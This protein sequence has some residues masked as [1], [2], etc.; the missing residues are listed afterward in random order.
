MD[1]AGVAAWVGRYEQAWRTEGTATLA[2]LFTADASYRTSPWAE[3][4][5]GLGAIQGMWEAERQGPHEDFAMVSEV[6]AV[7]GDTAVVRVEVVYRYQGGIRWRDLW[8]VRFASDGRCAA[9]EEWP[10]APGQDDGH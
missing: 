5:E 2:E 7:E 4:I 8:V 3:P 10:F 1:R 6:V 9:F